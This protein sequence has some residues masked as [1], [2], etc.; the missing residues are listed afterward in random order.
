MKIL[1]AEDDQRLSR[2]LQLLLRKEGYD[3]ISFSNGLSAYDYIKEGNPL[4]LAILDVMMPGMDGYTLCKK[5]KE[6]STTPVLILT[7]KSSVKDQIESLELGADEYVS[8]PFDN[9]VLLLRIKNILDKAEHAK[10]YEVGNLTLVPD[11]LIALVDDKDIDL[12]RKEYQVLELI[13][14]NRGS[15]VS[16]DQIVKEV[17]GTLPE[18]SRTVDTH[19]KTLRQKLGDHAKYLKT[20]YGVGYELNVE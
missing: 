15:V 18:N 17:W 10:F 3:V 4:D 14:T 16:K 13:V 6:S 8:K 7:A 19:I 9:E 20:V 5:I 2:I 1:L 12:S 11:K